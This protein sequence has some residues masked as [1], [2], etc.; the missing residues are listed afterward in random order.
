[1]HPLPSSLS[2]PRPLPSSSLAGATGNIDTESVIYALHSEGFHTGMDLVEAA[3][4]GE[5]ISKELGRES[6]SSAGRAVMAGERVKLQKERER[7][8]KL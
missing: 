7:E 3:K 1:M 4:I 5:W 8:S 2:N 6:G